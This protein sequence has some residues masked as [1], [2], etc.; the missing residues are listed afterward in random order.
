VPA[1]RQNLTIAN[2]DT[3]L[4]L[5]YLLLD[6]VRVRVARSVPFA[7]D[8]DVLGAR[9]QETWITVFDLS[10]ATARRATRV[11]ALEIANEDGGGDPEYA[12]AVA[13]LRLS[14]P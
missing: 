4:N 7:N 6:R 3:G 2:R 11:G 14:P 1:P 13:R 10:P 9:E 5:R 12:D 8:V